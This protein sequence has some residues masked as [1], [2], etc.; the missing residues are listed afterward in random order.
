MVI[1][2]IS[3]RRQSD[4]KEEPGIRIEGYQ[5]I[6]LDERLNK[7]TKV[8]SYTTHDSM[9]SVDITLLLKAIKERIQ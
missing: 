6:I 8:W 2:V 4:S 3:F 7:V 9:F 5:D 1:Q